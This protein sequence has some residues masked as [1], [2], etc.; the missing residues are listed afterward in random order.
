MLVLTLSK[1]VQEEA[2]SLGGESAGN[3]IA[4][5]RWLAYSVV[6]RSWEQS[7]NTDLELLGRRH[8]IWALWFSQGSG[9]GNR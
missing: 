7:E 1:E 6:S 5:Q 4:L 9:Q 3:S 8:L 2:C